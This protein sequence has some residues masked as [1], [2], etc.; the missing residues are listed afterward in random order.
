MKNI[1]EGMVPLSAFGIS[2]DLFF[3]ALG[4]TCIG[5]EATGVACPD[6]QY[7]VDAVPFQCPVDAVPV[8]CPVDAVPILCPVEPVPQPRPRPR[9]RLSRC[10]GS[11][12]EFKVLICYIKAVLME[13][14]QQDNQYKLSPL[15]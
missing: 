7:P 11:T 5:V 13:A 15:A 1:V 3:L 12:K 9:S 14:M 10:C 8:Q 6:V 2:S 4:L